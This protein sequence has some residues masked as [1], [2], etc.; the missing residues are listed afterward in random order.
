MMFYS[1]AYFESNVKATSRKVWDKVMIHKPEPKPTT[2]N[3]SVLSNQFKHAM[4]KE[5]DRAS[6]RY[7]INDFQA[8]K[9]LLFFFF[10]FFSVTSEWELS[11]LIWVEPLCVWFRYFLFIL[12]FLNFHHTLQNGKYASY[13]QHFCLLCMLRDLFN[14]AEFPSQYCERT[15]SEKY[16][17]IYV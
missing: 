13:F 7:G 14:W 17:L 12:F 4:E 9:W 1:V 6:F 2:H 10:F 3:L 8:M 15:N 5:S 11:C 16:K